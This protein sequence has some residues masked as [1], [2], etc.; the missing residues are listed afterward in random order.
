MSQELLSEEVVGRIKE[1]YELVN[2]LTELGHTI[3]KLVILKRGE[4]EQSYT[5]APSNKIRFNYRTTFLDPAISQRLLSVTNVEEVERGSDFQFDI[6]RSE[7]A[8]T[9]VSGP[10]YQ[11]ILTQWNLPDKLKKGN[12]E[13]YWLVN[14]RDKFPLSASNEEILEFV[15]NNNSDAPSN[16]LQKLPGGLP[17]FY[18]DIPGI[19][20]TYLGGSG[21]GILEGSILKLSLSERSI[22]LLDPKSISQLSVL[23]THIQGLEF[24][25]G[26]FQKGGGFMG[27][28]FGL[29]GFVIGAASSAVLNKI[30][31][32]TNIQTVMRILTS[33]GEMNFF[34][35]E[36]TPDQ[37]DMALADV[38]TGIR[39]REVNPAPV[40]SGIS[41]V[42]QLEK[43]VK[44]RD[45]GVLTNEEF[46]AQKS[47]I[48]NS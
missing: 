15:R 9:S 36:A 35:D 32:R 17:G 40:N 7:Q 4:T 37:L 11:S 19:N 31:T 38:R 30:T 25:G 47:K 10:V 21:Y 1:E 28:G 6:E 16:Q 29:G 2:A 18:H 39:N 27:G 3:S 24:D 5:L 23:F 22:D 8:F 42:E 45:Q 41:Q 43:L 44:L 20:V 14:N 46:D 33:E 48:L 12:S 13:Q 26:V 34:T